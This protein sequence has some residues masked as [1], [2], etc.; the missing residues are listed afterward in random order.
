[1][2]LTE[3]T[4]LKDILK[5]YPWLIDEAVKIDSR[6]SILRSPLGRALVAR[7]DI[8]EAGRKVGVS[9]EEIIAKVEELIADHS[10]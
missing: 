6:L 7:A 10:A 5:E 1:M 3:K 2:Q 8:A 4:K 9:P